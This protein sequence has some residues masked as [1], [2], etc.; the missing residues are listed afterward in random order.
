MEPWHFWALGALVF[1]IA[2]IFTPGFAL[3]CVSI[4]GIFGAVAAACELS[5]AWQIVLFAIGTF[6]A[7]LL[8]RPL[9]LKAMARHDKD[10]PK[11]NMGALIGRE[12]RVTEEIGPEGDTGRV[13]VDGDEWQAVSNDGQPIEVGAKVVILKYESII[14]TVKRQ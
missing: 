3:A 6:L 5:L 13:K 2:E 10:V 1:L 12:A 14:L 11:T 9:V 4:G 7:F 8:V